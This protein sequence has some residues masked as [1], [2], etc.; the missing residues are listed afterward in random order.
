MKYQ[1]RLWGV[2]IAILAL[3]VIAVK[4]W[5]MPLYKQYFTPKKVEAYVPTA[6]VREGRFV[7]SFQSIGT[8]QA[9][10]TAPVASEM[11]GKIVAVVAEGSMAKEGDVLVELDT[12]EI[13]KEVRDKQ[14]NH[15]NALADVTRAN[16]TL[17]ILRESNKTDLEKTQAQFD[18]DQGELERAKIDL[19]KMKLLAEEK[20]V[21][22]SDVEDAQRKVRQQELV[23]LKGTKDLALKKK[24][25][26]SKERQEEANVRKVQF[27]ADMSKSNLDEEM[28]HMKRA[29]IKAPTNGMVVLDTM[30]IGSGQRRKIKVGDMVERRQRV[31]DLPDLTSMLVKVSL[32][33]ADT[34]RISLE[35]PVTVR[36]D[37]IPNRVFHGTVKDISTLA[38]EKM[39]WEAGA[40]APGTK[41][42]DV[43]VALKEAD[44]RTLKPGM[45]A[46]VEF[47]CDTIKKT[48][49]VPI[50]SVAERNGK[51]HV[52]L[53]NGKRFE[54]TIVETGKANDSFVSITKGLRKG[55]LVALRDPTA[56]GEEQ[57]TE[58]AVTGANGSASAPSPTPMPSSRSGPMVRPGRRR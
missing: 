32:G 17:G 42:F 23:V 55:Q 36:L 47:I 7:V 5:G 19:E 16:E 30:Y 4:Q 35:L 45:T 3:I 28:R 29:I 26:E 27:A 13:E 46:N 43:T 14:L 25:T 9:E 21:K 52:F 49:Y 44:P 54:R 2:R 6:P 22:T 37:A 41:N 51:T 24:E 50:E 33:E 15:Q 20:L 18:F 12:T 53:K 58:S 8:L 40:A 31:C 10:N 38:T 56:R 48:A 57:E 34:P 11:S 1:L 39:P